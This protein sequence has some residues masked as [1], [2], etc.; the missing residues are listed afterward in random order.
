MLPLI[1]EPVLFF[2]G[3][4]VSTCLGVKYQKAYKKIIQNG[5]TAEGIVFEFAGSNETWI[6]EPAESPTPVIRFVTNKQQWI[7]Q[8]ATI[9]FYSSGLKQGDKVTVIYNENEPE[10]FIIKS[11]LTTAWV[12][13]LFIIAGVIAML[14]SG[15]YILLKLFSGETTV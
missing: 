2:I 9:S 5:I 1:I 14:A 3:G 13:Y 4:L 10:Q 7:T 11:F 15:I 8:E 6:G 12:H